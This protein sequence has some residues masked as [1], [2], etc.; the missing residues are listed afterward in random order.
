LTDKKP[1][2][3]YTCAD[4]AGL[5]AAQLVDTRDPP[6]VQNICNDDFAP[7]EDI[8]NNIPLLYN[9]SAKVCDPNAVFRLVLPVRLN[10]T[11]IESELHIKS[12]ISYALAVICLIVMGL[13]RLLPFNQR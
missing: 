7:Y 1:D 5:N 6:V 8:C 11:S 13:F 10:E 3:E 9:P 2:V 4:R 12:M